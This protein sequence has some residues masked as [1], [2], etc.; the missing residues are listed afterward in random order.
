MYNALNAQKTVTEL[1]NAIN[2]L[3]SVELAN[4]N[5]ESLEM[6]IGHG[7]VDL[8]LAVELIDQL[9]RENEELRKA[10]QGQDVPPEEP[11]N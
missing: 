6:I 11:S 2:T 8:S 3:R 10:H 9:A 7:L 5:F 1:R 4:I